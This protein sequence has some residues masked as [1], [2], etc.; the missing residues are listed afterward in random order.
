MCFQTRNK[1]EKI[2]FNF[3]NKKNIG[4]EHKAVVY[5]FLNLII[6]KMKK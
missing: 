2:V 5:L 6:Q 4:F 1:F 3:L